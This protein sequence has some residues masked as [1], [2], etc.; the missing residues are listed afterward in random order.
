VTAR[1][2]KDLV[3]IAIRKRVLRAVLEGEIIRS[4]PEAARLDRACPGS[5]LSTTEISELLVRVALKAGV[6]T[7]LCPPDEVRTAAFVGKSPTRSGAAGRD[8]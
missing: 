2:G 3:D 4:G 8:D 5:G 6:A 1:S 7:E